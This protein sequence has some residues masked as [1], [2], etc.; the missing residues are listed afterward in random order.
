VGKT[1]LAVALAHDPDVQARFPDGVLWAGLGR[2]P[3]LL[4]IMSRWGTQ[5]GMGTDQMAHLADPLSWAQALQQ[6][7]GARRLLLVIDDA[8][9][10]E[11][12]LAF[13]VGGPACVYLLT[14]RSAEVALQFAD[15]R[16][17][18]IPELSEEA[19]LALLAQFVP[20]VVAAAHE[21]AR[22]L[23]RAVGGLPLGLMLMGK[24]LQ[25]HSFGRQPR[26]LSAALER[27]GQRV[28]RLQLQVPQTPLAPHPSLPADTPLSLHASIELSV[29]ALGPEAQAM[30]RALAVF[31]PKP[32]SFSEE[33]ALTVSA[34]AAET[35][36]A[37]V[38]AGLVESRGA[39]R[40][41]LHQTISD[42]A[43]LQG[44]P[45]GT[46]QRFI[47]WAVDWIETCQRDLL[48]LEQELSLLLEALRLAM[49]DDFHPLLI[50][51]STM[52][53]SFL[54]GRGLYAP[55]EELLRQAQA[56]ARALGDMP[57]LIASLYQLGRVAA[58]R[59]AYEQAAAYYQE[60]IDLHAWGDLQLATAQWEDAK[61]AYTEA[62]G[63]AR[64]IKSRELEAAAWYGLARLAAAQG[65]LKQA[66]QQGQTSLQLYTAQGLYQ[67]AEVK[68]WLAR[69]PGSIAEHSNKKG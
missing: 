14:T 67:A 36:D 30:L 25:V 9:R 20:Q 69:L 32:A 22:S 66:Y 24:H 21:Q 7:I 54:L 27:L 31:P 12:A 43:R 23:V 63:L 1:A 52:L 39:G 53:A 16:I 57:G 41:A 15:E 68:A 62:R 33:V 3:H 10:I 29:D 59:G 55:A 26:R 47:A 4:E 45:P 60:G 46:E 61:Q 44:V 37:L 28:E 42:Y 11:D 35:L 18:P 65:D 40:Y 56:A 50:R 13:R 34:G 58:R 49:K 19:S 8:W 17:A 5:L 64:Q 38:D 6:A 2:Q 48:L 51:G